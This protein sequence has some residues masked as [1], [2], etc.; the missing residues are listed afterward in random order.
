M[1]PLSFY[2]V[3]F[4]VLSLAQ[5]RAIE[6]DVSGT[7]SFNISPPTSTD[8]ANWNTG[9][10]SGGVTGWDYVGTVNGASGV[11]LGNNWVLT[12]GHVG[13]GT[14]VLGGTSYSVLAGSTHGIVNPDS[15]IA[16]LTLFEL[17]S[18]PSLP[19]LTIAG[20]APT[21][22]SATQSGSMVAMIGYGGGQGETWGLNTVTDVNLPIEVT[23]GSS[24]YSSTD[25]ATEYGTI[26]A[27]LASVTN[28]YVLV[29]GDSGGGDFIYN[30]ASSSWMLSGI[31]EAVDTN[32]NS[33]MVQL[34]AYASQIDSITGVPEPSSLGLLGLGLGFLA[35]V[36]RFRFV[37]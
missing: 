8:I 34:N 33:Y 16:D 29:T 4:M 27:G 17:S 14:F 31:N 7:I 12:A 25:F 18:A 11:Y 1:K 28:D 21:A 26:T 13:S 32:Q 5:A 22:F 9:W 20:S 36:W 6:K 3:L 35:L 37:S 23:V 10:G 19:S 30:S 2:F 15:T 24:T